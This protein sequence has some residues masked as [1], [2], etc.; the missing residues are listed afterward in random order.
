MCR[1][2]FQTG[3]E[4]LRP[5]KD[6]GSL[7]GEAKRLLGLREEL[8]AEE[9]RL[10]QGRL[11]LARRHMDTEHVPVPQEEFDRWFSAGES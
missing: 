8:R 10:A 4:D 6:K 5:Q 3:V 9:E 1:A 11:A 7:L 2:T